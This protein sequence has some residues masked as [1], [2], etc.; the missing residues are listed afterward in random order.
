MIRDRLGM[1]SLVDTEDGSP[2]AVAIMDQKENTKRSELKVA[3]ESLEALPNFEGNT[4]T[5]DPLHCQK[6]WE[7]LAQRG[8]RAQ[9]GVV[10]SSLTDTEQ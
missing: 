4:V 6:E 2:V 10:L 5:A 9:P 7:V 1:V 3:H 8:G